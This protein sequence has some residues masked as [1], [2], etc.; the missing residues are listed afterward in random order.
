MGKQ[1]KF[2]GANALLEQK[3]AAIQADREQQVISAG[4]PERELKVYDAKSQPKVTSVDLPMSYGKVVDQKLL[5]QAMDAA[6]VVPQGFQTKAMRDFNELQGAKVYTKATIKVQFPDGLVIQANFSPLE[7]LTDVEAVVKQCMRNP[8]KAPF[9]LFERPRREKLRSDQTLQKLGLVP[10][11]KLFAAWEA[12]TP[13]GEYVKD[14]LLSKLDAS[15]A[16]KPKPKEK[17]K[18][19]SIFF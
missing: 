6:Y 4:I 3:V 19:R 8:E 1:M 15:Q 13:D 18:R 9:Y 7:R 2:S 11:T 17:Q 5:K 14:E 12:E 10:A 16:G